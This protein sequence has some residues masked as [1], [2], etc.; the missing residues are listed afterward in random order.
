[1]REQ[2][3]ELAEEKQLRIINAALE[4]FSQNEYKRAVTDD[5]A[6]KAQISK[7]LLFYYFHNKKELYMFLYNYCEKVLTEEVVDKH[8]EEITDFFELLEHAARRKVKV[9]ERTPYFMEFIMKA[10]YSKSE[11]VTEEVTNAL[12]D[13][14]SVIFN[15]YFKSIDFSKFKDD[16]DPQK[17]LQMITWMADGY[18]HEKTQLGLK[19]QLEEMMTEFRI[20][21]VMLKKISYKEEYLIEYN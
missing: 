6:A 21:V 9:L 8:F 18:L 10:F 17:I 2:F 20:W 14:E 4:V 12:K 13:S 15:N 1:M 16:V 3:Y 7:G 5:I 19:V 11:D